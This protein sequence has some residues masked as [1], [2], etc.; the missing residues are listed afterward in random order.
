MTTL[1]SHSSVEGE[2]KLALGFPAGSFKGAGSALADGLREEGRLV[3][4]GSSTPW[5]F[6]SIHQDE[7]GAYLVG[8]DFEGPSLDEAFASASSPDVFLE[9]LLSLSKALS[10][11]V[12]EDSLP[13]GL[14]SPGILLSPPGEDSC[15]TL[16]L[17]PNTA[18]KALV[19][20]GPE[21]RA[22]AL[23]RLISPRSDC[24]EA[25]ASFLLAQAAYRA[26][27]GQGAY[28]REAA[29]AS[30]V[31][32]SRRY[33]ISTAL[34]SPRLD[35]ALSSLIDTAL[36]DPKSVP[37]DSWI[38]ALEAARAAGWFRAIDPDEEASLRRQREAVEAEAEKR[39]R[40]SEFL[41]K[42]GGILIGVAI[43][44]AAVGIFAGSMIRSQKDKPDYSWLSPREL[45]QRYYLSLED[46][47]LDSLEACSVKKA[48]ESDWNYVM[49]ITVLSKTRMA[50]EGKSPV[51]RAGDWV[52]E[53]K[54][55][56]TQNEL[57][58][59]VAGLSISEESSASDKA[60]LRASYSFWSLDRVDDPS[61][62][63]AKARQV[64]TEEKR[65]DELSLAR[66]KQGGWKI[67][68]MDRSVVH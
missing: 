23:A 36:D 26:L 66:D 11:L 8:P 56:L 42:K 12:A 61:G 48:V 31:S 6:E 45:V 3:S 51:L 35:G 13:R 27:A 10:L 53:G 44:L 21:A 67:V 4:L 5:R 59:G 52:A 33:T 60:R 14:I 37:L 30:A 32:P 20:R 50:Y 2:R 15:A 49:N 39:R 43:G 16:L 38:A 65:I 29:D 34:V 47:D 63:P 28:Q 1:V 17:P 7:S 9:R 19:S 68:A 24:P 55:Q 40:R 64:P 18:A 41:R 57:L 22:D 25:D 62:D 46:L 58:Y 54:P